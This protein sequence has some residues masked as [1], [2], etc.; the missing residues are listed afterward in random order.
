MHF[1]LVGHSEAD[2]FRHYVF[3]RVSQKGERTAFTV[4][5]NLLLIRRFGIRIQE[6]PL[7]C[8]ALLESA[9]ETIDSCGF[10]LS[11]E[12]LVE[13][14]LRSAY[15]TGPKKKPVPV[16][17]RG[18]APDDEDIQMNDDRANELDE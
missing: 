8:R 9:P 3:E 1:A 12:R 2:G 17:H 16:N 6:L 18:G 11:E 13:H 7:M 4:S 5:A 14:R 10:S 15:Q